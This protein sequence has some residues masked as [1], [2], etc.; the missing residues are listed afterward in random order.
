MFSV[1]GTQTE[2]LDCLRSDNFYSRTMLFC[3]TRSPSDILV[4][5]Y[6]IPTPGVPMLPLRRLF[7]AWFSK[8][9]QLVVRPASHSVSLND[10]QRPLLKV[11][12][13]QGI[14]LVEVA[15]ILEETGFRGELDLTRNKAVN[16]SVMGRS[17][18]ASL[19]AM[20]QSL[21]DID[22]NDPTACQLPPY[23]RSE[24]GMPPPYTP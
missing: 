12:A 6:R 18:S 24:D 19:L 1:L 23:Q 7:D 20:A 22:N 14:T 5:V 11:H 9:R 16:I 15:R 3:N 2:I 17:R 13:P 4:E 8:N 10:Y 21:D